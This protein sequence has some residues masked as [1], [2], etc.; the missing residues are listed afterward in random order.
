M[1]KITLVSLAL[2]AIASINAYADGYAPI[3]YMYYGIDY[4][5]NNYYGT[6]RSIALGNA[7]T[8][9]GGDMGSFGI[10]PAGSAVARYGQ[11]VITPAL[12]LFSSVSSY[13]P[14][15]TDA[16]G[17]TRNN[18]DGNRF[19]VP[20]LG[21]SMAMHTGNDRGLKA[22]SFAFL[23]N[24]T[25]NYNSHVIA[26]GVNNRTS[27]LSE[28]AS[29]A[30]FNQYSHEALNSFDSGI[31][32]DLVT[33][34]R[35]RLFG[36]IGTNSYAGNS[37]VSGPAGYCVPDN[38]RQT[39]TLVT[40][41]YKSDILFNLGFN[42]SDEL[43]IGFNFGIQ[44]LSYNYS[45]SYVEHAV[46][47]QKFPI[48]LPDSKGW[49]YDTYYL[50]VVNSFSRRADLKGSYFKAGLIWLP[51]KG[52]RL[53]AAI[54]SPTFFTIVES[55]QH[56]ASSTYEYSG[57]NASV[58]SPVDEWQYSMVSP[59]II[60]LGAAFTFGNFGLLSM[61]YEMADYN[62]MRMKEAGSFSSSSV[63]DYF[64]EVNRITSKFCGVAN[65]LRIGA[66]IKPLPMIAV[67]A[68]YSLLGRP[69]RVWH[70]ASDPSV[71]VTA[72]MYASNPSAFGELVNP[73][74][75]GVI[76]NSFS[77]GLGYSSPSSFFA[78]LAVRFTGRPQMSYV[79]YFDYSHADVQGEWH[80]FGT[81][82]QELS[83]RVEY[84]EKM[85]DIALTIGWRF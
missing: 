52:V 53:G 4:S 46:N 3:S 14:V 68:G 8:A 64:Y 29:T 26:G 19:S 73:K 24:Q 82:S 76:T 78:D 12:S 40:E 21:L 65:S 36:G 9:L 22:I 49:M 43:F 83:P 18:A 59:Y 67:R 2:V 38:L 28:Y 75:T 15:G 25:N 42:F 23:S 77:F 71:E 33:A 17:L 44:S 74:K 30:T 84:K 60:N 61:D 11:V 81:S 1:K 47:S 37:S 10:N 32:W 50:G 20:N 72:E 56:S 62:V 51:V 55:M 13:T 39:S 7:V 31:P 58:L 41:G 66:E 45:E 79:P 48:E 16:H 69:E 54:Q 34:Y 85:V 57:C 5:Q 70:S 27:L 80:E 63:N 6:A 35:A